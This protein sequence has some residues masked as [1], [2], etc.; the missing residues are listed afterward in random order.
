[1][2]SIVIVGGGITGLSLAFRLSSRPNTQVTL[3]EASDRLG[4]NIRTIHK[5]GF[6]IEFGPNGFL[7]SS[8]A[9]VQLARDVG[10]GDKLIA[11]SESSSRKRYLFLGDRLHAL[12]NS[13]GRLLRLP[14]LSMRGKLALLTEP[15]RACRRD[16]GPESVADF[17]RRRAGREA[18]D[19]FADALVTGIHGGDSELL[20]VRSAF[21]RLVKFET[22]DGSVI[23]GMRN[24]AKRKRAAGEK[25]ARPKL[26]SFR[27][28]LE[29]LIAALAERLPRPPFLGVAVRRIE[30][31]AK[32]WIVH[33]EGNDVWTADTVVLTCPA[34]QQ[35]R[36]VADLDAELAGLL[37][38]IAYN[39]IAVVALGYSADD[40]PR[41][42]DGFGYIAPQRLRRDMLGVQWCS[43]IFPARA[44]HGFVLWRALCGGW[45]RGDVADWPD[46][47]LVSAVRS[48]IR[49]ATGVDAQPMF[50]LV[51][52]W[53]QAI[54]QYL[55]GHPERVAAIEA[56]AAQHPGLILGGN[57]LHGIS[58]NDCVEWSERTA[59]SLIGLSSP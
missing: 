29:V 45:H 33:G 37:A 36:I 46:D 15:L 42:Y 27:D 35:A 17:A 32:G 53:P 50:T 49:L 34:Y 54:P 40:V 39:R 28:G 18:A 21:P 14:L 12:P 56:R 48:E 20:D 44:P 3:L 26:W 1:M 58:L 4:G 16:G 47:R 22:E 10:L 57:A 9:T 38:E 59:G 5:D 2:R 23:R 11:A 8:P 19:L 41:A 6:T 13:I 43:A 51:L 55:L 24:A 30:R 25:P 7:D 52:R 31:V